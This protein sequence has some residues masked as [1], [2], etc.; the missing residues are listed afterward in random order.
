M[1]S[2]LKKN[3]YPYFR[4]DIQYLHKA[5]G[6]IWWRESCAWKLT[7]LD[8]LS[9]KK[10]WVYTYI[11]EL[12]AELIYYPY[13]APGY[14][15]PEGKKLSFHIRQQ[16][17]SPEERAFLDFLIEYQSERGINNHMLGAALTA[18]LH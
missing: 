2:F 6:H 13:D 5:C 11:Q 17:L 9:V 8:I 10:G 12:K 1:C 7:Q 15:A 4:L 16:P 14:K 3:K 18:S